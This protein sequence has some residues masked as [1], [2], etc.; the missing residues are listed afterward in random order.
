[1]SIFKA[2]DIRGVYGK[3]LN[4]IDAYM[5]GYYF[6][7]KFKIN[8]LKIA[9]DLRLSYEQLTK[10]LIKGILDANSKV[11]YLG[12]SSTPNFYFSLFKGVN[13]GIMVTASHNPKEYNGFK[14]MFNGLSF[15]SSNGLLEIENL[16]KKDNDNIKGNF[17]LIEKELKKISFDSF[18]LKNNITKQSTLEDYSNYLYNYYEKLLST[19]EKDYLG[20][21]IFTLDYSSGVSSL[22]VEKFLDKTYLR[23]NILNQIP[24]GNFPNHSPDPFEAK[25]YIKNMKV[26]EEADNLFTAVFDGD[27]DRIAF[28]DENNEFISPDLTI[29]MLIDYFSDQGKNFVCD[30]RVSRFISDMQKEKKIKVDLIR[31]GRAFYTKHMVENNCIFGG[32]LSGHLFFKEFHNFDNPDLALIYILKII[33]SSSFDFSFSKY[34]EKYKKYYKINETNLKVKNP[35]LIFSKLESKYSK[36]LVMKLDG[37]SFDLGDYW[38]NIRKSNTEPIIRINFEGRDKKITEKEMKNLI[39]FINDI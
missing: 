28:F 7:K 35:D 27:G 9:H 2:Y 36:N 5:F 10:F 19:E 24:D 4:E 15:D 1:M 31:V 32:E 22:G 18:L 12:E 26:G 11:I 39:K 25:D 29:G 21:N 38:F 13:T 14:I 8:E 33:A 30:L 3:E 34:I 16:V 17:I 6:C 20:A 37:L 23:Y